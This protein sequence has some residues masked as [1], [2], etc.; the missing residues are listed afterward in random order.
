MLEVSKAPEPKIQDYA[1]QGR[2][3]TAELEIDELDGALMNDNMI[4]NKVVNKLLDVMLTEKCI[5]FTKQY[6][7]LT[8]SYMVRS[9]IYVTPDTQVKILRELQ[10]SQFKPL[11]P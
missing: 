11:Y 1:I 6:N 8:N 4:K 3:I 5:E 2:M 7:P 10:K 9:R